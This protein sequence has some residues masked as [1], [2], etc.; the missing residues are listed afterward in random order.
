M[1]VDVQVRVVE[2]QI[3]LEQW[4]KKNMSWNWL[5]TRWLRNFG[6]DGSESWGVIR[7]LLCRHPERLLDRLGGEGKEWNLPRCKAAKDPVEPRGVVLSLVV[8]RVVGGGKLK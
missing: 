6:R 4:M 3:L 2:V 1:I 5:G 8:V 7:E